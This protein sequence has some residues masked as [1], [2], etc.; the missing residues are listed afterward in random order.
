MTRFDWARLPLIALMLLLL[1][2]GAV[3]L[4]RDD[5]SP[6]AVVLLTGGMILLGVWA[7]LEII[8]WWQRLRCD[9]QEDDD[10]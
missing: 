8:E 2:S 9:D 4:I 10:G 5:Q 1:I 3:T 7:T 6:T